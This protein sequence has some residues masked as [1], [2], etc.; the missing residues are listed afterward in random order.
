MI[1]NKKQVANLPIF[2]SLL[3]LTLSLLLSVPLSSHAAPSA[4]LAAS[5]DSSGTIQGEYNRASIY[6]GKDNIM[7][8]DGNYIA[9]DS[10]GANLDPSH[11]TSG[12]VYTYLKNMSTGDAHL[13]SL[14][15]TGDLPNQDTL[16]V[17]AIN[18]DASK[19]FFATAATNMVSNDSSYSYKIYER[20]ISTGSLKIVSLDENNAVISDVQNFS[21]SSDGRYVMFNSPITPINNT[22]TVYIRDTVDNSTQ[23]II[24]SD[25]DSGAEEISGNGQYILYFSATT[26]ELMRYS[27]SDASIVPVSL[28]QNGNVQ[29]AASNVMPAISFD[30]NIVA[31]GSN[32][33]VALWNPQGTLE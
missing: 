23:K 32:K 29:P 16:G 10:N 2:G 28:D 19:V 15:E 9:F 20:D 24:L 1:I 27:V 25:S 4:T 21:I 30:G 17:Y 6:G 3:V 26:L 7:S 11:P 5:T 18:A 14:T 33:F 12:G 13:V 22:A 8:S 31:F